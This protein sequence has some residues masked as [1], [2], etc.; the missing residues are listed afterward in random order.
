M[1]FSKAKFERRREVA[2]M[3]MVRYQL[4]PQRVIGPSYEA[5]ALLISHPLMSGC[6]LLSG[7]KISLKQQKRRVYEQPSIEKG[8]MDVVEY[9]QAR[10]NPVQ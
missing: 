10:S 5:L 7:P 9:C 8:R 3:I 2:F 4:R 1:K 6:I